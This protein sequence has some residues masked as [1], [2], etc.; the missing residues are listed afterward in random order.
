[1]KRCLVLA[2]AFLLSLGCDS[3]GGATD[4][5]VGGNA[6]FTNRAILTGDQ[7]GL[8]LDLPSKLSRAIP[9]VVDGPQ[10]TGTS[11]FLGR[12]SATGDSAAM[13]VPITNLADHW[14]CYVE[15]STFDLLDQAGVSLGVSVIG[16][17][18]YGSVGKSTIDSGANGLHTNTCLEP[19]GTGYFF[20]F[21]STAVYTSLGSLH[22]ELVT[23]NKVYGP[24]ATSVVPLSYKV[25]SPD[26][27]YTVTI[28]NQGPTAATV[29]GGYAVYLNDS[30]IPVFWEMLDALGGATPGYYSLAPGASAQLTSDSLVT[31][32]TGKS[33]KQ[34]VIVDFDGYVSKKSSPDLH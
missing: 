21:V 26:Q 2:G 8:D 5:G 7:V 29:Y 11:A 9:V 14:Q 18:M 28:A 27:P 1:M 23:G 13:V 24:P 33:T 6:S 34:I 3:S 16:T 19:G 32:W 31:E 30:D 20:E 12:L 22:L 4:G 25:T 15:A 17:F 10:L